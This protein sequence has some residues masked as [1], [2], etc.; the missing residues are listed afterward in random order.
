[1]GKLTRKDFKILEDLKNE[2]INTNELEDLLKKELTKETWKEILKGKNFSEKAIQ[3]ILKHIKFKWKNDKQPGKHS[4]SGIMYCLECNGLINAKPVRGEN[5][6]YICGRANNGNCDSPP[7]KSKLIED[8]IK[9]IVIKRLD[10]FI[11]V[12]I[13]DLEITEEE[14]QKR[15]KKLLSEKR[16]AIKLLPDGIRPIKQLFNIESRVYSMDNRDD[17]IYDRDNKIKSLED[18]T[19]LQNEFH[20]HGD[21]EKA[22][23]LYIE[24]LKK[25]P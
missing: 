18:R 3:I 14:K 25:C 5:K 24:K 12:L 9:D 22:R 13:D 15:I 17:I 16:Q 4:L 21:C 23:E 8:K 11:M 7:V 6:Y 19:S 2:E 20:S 1:M 10:N